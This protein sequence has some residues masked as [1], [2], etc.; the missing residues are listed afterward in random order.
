MLFCSEIFC[1]GLESAVVIEDYFDAARGP[2]IL[3]LEK[4]FNR[5]PG[6]C[7]LGYPKRHQGSG[8]NRDGLP[9]RPTAVVIRL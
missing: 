5:P 8:G 9:T 3:V 6:S 1:S 4:G 2:T 7:C